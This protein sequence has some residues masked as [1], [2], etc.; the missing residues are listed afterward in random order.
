MQVLI[1][2]TA[3]QTLI[4]AALGMAALGLVILLVLLFRDF[5]NG[6]IW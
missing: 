5:R 3:L 6:A 2:S 1:S 4:Y